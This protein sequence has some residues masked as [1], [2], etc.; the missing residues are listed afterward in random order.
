MHPI[1]ATE[2]GADEINWMLAGA[3]EYLSIM[4]EDLYIHIY[5]PYRNI[6]IMLKK[7]TFMC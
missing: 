7:V 1:R 2:M 3:G 4:K 6:L 5:V